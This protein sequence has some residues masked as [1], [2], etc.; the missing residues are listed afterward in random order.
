MKALRGHISGEGNA[1]RQ[2]AVA[3][4]LEFSLHYKNKRPMAF[5]VFL[6]KCQKMFTIFVDEGKAKDKKAKIR[7]LFMAVLRH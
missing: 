7:F 2:I 6:T 5:E 4:T 1:T 3:E